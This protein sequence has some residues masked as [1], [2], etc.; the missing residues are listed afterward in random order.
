MPRVGEKL[1]TR[2]WTALVQV[3][4]LYA[5]STAFAKQP[6]HLE[7]LYCVLYIGFTRLF[8]DSTHPKTTQS[9]LLGVE[10]SPFSTRPITNTKL[11]NKDLYS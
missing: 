9:N 10:L 11:I 4:G 5:K 6:A 7:N 8:S 3:A 1:L 2:L